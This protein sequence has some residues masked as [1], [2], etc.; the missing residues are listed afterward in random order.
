V[1]VYNNTRRRVSAGRFCPFLGRRGGKLQDARAARV[2]QA[3]LTM[4]LNDTG[5][6][7]AQ[8]HS[9]G[10][11]MVRCLLP[12]NSLRR[13]PLKPCEKRTIKALL[14][15]S[16]SLGEIRIHGNGCACRKFAL[17]RNGQKPLK[18]HIAMY[19]NC[20]RKRPGAGRPP[21]ASMTLG[22]RR[23]R[24]SPGSTKRKRLRG[25]HVIGRFS[26]AADFAGVRNSEHGPLTTAEPFKSPAFGSADLLPGCT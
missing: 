18:A 9:P 5:K 14:P 13:K 3:P 8:V 26:G 11:L 23:D 22:N 17:P 7:T 16:I 10:K 1:L 6:T 20:G 15:F 4:E 12:R 2:T 19:H 21:L 25:L 24:E